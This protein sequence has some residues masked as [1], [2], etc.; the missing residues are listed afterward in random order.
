[1]W[2]AVLLVPSHLR[3][4]GTNEIVTF[5][6]VELEMFWLHC[7]YSSLTKGTYSEDVK[8]IRETQRWKLQGFYIV[9]H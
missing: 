3:G 8:K 2:E 1:M 4:Q 5:P 6:N 9:T 7:E